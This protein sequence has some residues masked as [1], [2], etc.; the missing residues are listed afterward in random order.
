M[1]FPSTPWD[2]FQHPRLR[3]PALESLLRCSLTNACVSP[4]CA[5]QR[6]LPSPQIRFSLRCP[7]VTPHCTFQLTVTINLKQ[8]SALSVV[9]CCNRLVAEL[10]CLSVPVA[11]V[12]LYVFPFRFYLVEDYRIKIITASY[13]L[14]LLLQLQ[15][16]LMHLARLYV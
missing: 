14:L 12:I 15:F 3:N 11:T 9:F 16:T 13:S 8:H 7:K 5:E 10:S 1:T 6:W 4:N 2:W